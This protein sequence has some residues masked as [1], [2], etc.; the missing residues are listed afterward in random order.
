MYKMK[1]IGA[2]IEQLAPRNLAMDDDNIGLIVGRLNA[3][4]TKVLLALDATDEV[5]DEA[6]NLGCQAIITHHPPIWKPIKRI[7]DDCAIERRLL[8]LIENGIAVYSAHTNLDFCEGGIN[9]LLFDKLGL[10]DKELIFEEKPGVFAGRAGL[11]LE[12]MPL[13][14]FVYFIEGQLNLDICKYVGDPAAQVRKVGVMAGATARP[15]FF[16]AM[17]AA[18]CDTYVT[19]DIVY[20][21]ALKAKDLGLNLVDATHYASEVIFTEILAEYLAERLPKLEV[22]VSKID[23]QVFKTGGI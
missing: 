12:P 3:E 22:L 1:E 20:T 4:I 6:I 14:E 18:G 19:S 21:N 8:A 2:A 11:M 13:A 5:I 15:H 17:A 7:A 23:G 9:D 16:E 10:T